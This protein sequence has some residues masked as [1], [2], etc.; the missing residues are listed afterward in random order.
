MIADLLE[1]V[2]ATPPEH[3]N[4][5]IALASQY[6][7]EAGLAQEW[8]AAIAQ[9]QSQPQPQPQPQVKLSRIQAMLQA[10]ELYSKEHGFH[11]IPIAGISA[12]RVDVLRFRPAP[13][14]DVN[15]LDRQIPNLI[16]RVP[17]LLATPAP[18]VR[19]TND[20]GIE[21]LAARERWTPCHLADWIRPKEWDP[22]D[23][24]TLVW[25]VG[26]DGTPCE[27]EV[28]HAQ[29][30]GGTGS[31]KTG[32]LNS[33]LGQIPI[34][35][36]PW[37]V[38]WILLDVEQ[39]GLS[40]FDDQAHFWRGVHGTLPDRSID[41]YAECFEALKE[42]LS[43]HERRLGL[44]KQSRTD[45]IRRYNR[46]A[47]EPLPHLVVLIDEVASLRNNV[48]AAIASALDERKSEAIVAEG[49]ILIDRLFEEIAMRCRKTGIHLILA[50]Q[51][52]DK[53]TIDVKIRANLGTKIALRCADAGTSNIAFGYT[54]DWAVRL[55]GHGDMWL[56][57]GGRVDRCQG[58]Y[59]DND[60][61]VDGSTRLESLLRYTK[62][63]YA[64]HP[65]VLGR[66]KSQSQSQSQSQSPTA[67]PE[68][69]DLWAD[70]PEPC[71]EESVDRQALLV[72][73]RTLKAAGVSDRQALIEVFGHLHPG[74]P[75]SATGGNS[76]R[77][78]LR[79]ISEW[80]ESSHA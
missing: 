69:E 79:W 13:A 18:V 57:D 25:G 36:K 6:A 24:F 33:L 46:T 58:L 76:R 43:E 53:D 39:V 31:G 7:M 21:I 51:R 35:Y 40:A 52:A 14:T 26:I 59:V 4:D 15:K 19:L 8:S 75:E 3:R 67:R 55:T 72:Q 49:K 37:Q 41:D 47:N 9:P 77:K 61:V 74:S 10:I 22:W 2:K 28:V 34:R 54:C 66:S 50:T 45:S 68:V 65:W 56:I 71:Q 20:N 32:V 73:W 62:S 42:V 70:D 27:R 1:L 44:L 64:N 12:P 78:Y 30:T 48:G 29:I 17:G 80:E 38:Q 16:V 11:L 63:L 60:E 5:A 23:P